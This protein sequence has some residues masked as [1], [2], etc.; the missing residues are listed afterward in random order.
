MELKMESQKNIG[1]SGLG[2]NM[3]SSSFTLF[4]ATCSDSAAVHD[5]NQDFSGL[6]NQLGK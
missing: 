6:E 5:P 4:Q 2:N 3:K 1:E